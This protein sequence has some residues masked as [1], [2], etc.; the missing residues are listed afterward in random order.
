MKAILR[1]TNTPVGS[2]LLCLGWI[3]LG[4]LINP[5]QLNAQLPTIIEGQCSEG[6]GDNVFPQGNF[7]RVETGDIWVGRTNNFDG[8][9]RPTEFYITEAPGGVTTYN[10]GLSGYNQSYPDDGN[11]VLA[12]N[13]FGMTPG[14]YF[15]N[16]T[17]Q[18][19]DNWISIEDNSPDKN[20]H[21]M[22]VNA[23]YEPGIFYQGVVEDLCGGNVYEFT[24]DMINI[25]SPHSNNPGNMPNISFILAP[26]NTSLQDLQNMPEIYNTGDI[27][28]DATWH[29]YGFNFT[30]PAGETEYL[31]AIRN[32]APGGNGNDLAIDNISFRLCG[33][34]ARIGPIDNTPL[35]CGQTA[36]DLEVTSL[37]NM[38]SAFV[39]WQISQ[40]SGYTW[41]DLPQA[42]ELSYSVASANSVDQYRIKVAD[43]Q[44][45]LDKLACSLISNVL[46]FEVEDTEFL[47][48]TADT[49]ICP[50]ASI[51]LNAS[52]GAVQYSWSP[53]R[54]LSD[55]AT[56]NPVALP[57]T[58]TTYYVEAVNQNGC[59]DRDTVTITLESNLT[60][61]AGPDTSI[62]AGSSFTLEGTGGVNYS[63]SP[64]TGLDNPNQ[65]RPLA[66]PTSSIT[67]FLR[68]DDGLGC[69]GRDTVTIT[70]VDVPNLDAGPDTS[71][72]LGESIMLYANSEEVLSWDS[73]ASLSQLDIANPLANPTETTRYWVRS[74]IGECMAV[75]SILVEVLPLPNLMVSEDD[76]LCFGSEYQLSASGA[77]SFTWRSL[78]GQTSFS[79][80]DTLILIE[81]DQSWEVE[82]RSTVGCISLDTVNLITQPLPE[83]AIEPFFETCL[84]DELLIEPEGDYDYLWSNGEVGSMLEYIALDTML[85]DFWVLPVS[86]DACLGDTLSFSVQGVYNPIA[87]FDLDED[88]GFGPLTVQFTNL[89]RL[90]TDYIWDF[91]GELDSNAVDPVHVFMEPGEYDILLTAI[92]RLGCLDTAS[93]QSVEVLEPT[94]Y[95]PNSFSPNGDGKNDV[96]RIPQVGFSELQMRIFDRWGKLIVESYDLDF[97][98]DGKSGG[99]PVPEG[100]YVC[101]LM[102][103]T[104]TGAEVKRNI[105]ITLIR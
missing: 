3:S 14:T 75:D 18:Q 90:A 16:I 48:V 88:E 79:S 96:F 15:S 99:S 19:E 84:E 38:D 95:F 9:D 93:Y 70:V 27:P 40:D 42:D 2:I 55:S 37:G 17:N 32:N 97:G 24:V 104:G 58:S 72:C 60:V 44:A 29:T 11:Y 52:S 83:A 4:I 20:G 82:G 31:L 23:G 10:Y 21:M 28:N 12:N 77:Q 56:A 51:Q 46:S 1:P 64:A 76:S 98:W 34:S 43:I 67:Y 7:G 41:T 80:A 47:T 33:D 91:G 74:G 78:T 100:V 68:A 105:A 81:E 36:V 45:N 59:I 102:A 25:F 63:W 94:L 101:Q 30:L 26:V 62:C 92:N 57:D 69:E 73:A 87:A 39:Q 8:V 6:K 49:S 65:A 61:N 5:T 89:S 85:R 66:L 103:R 71:V 35:I 13:T 22:I 86:E 54:S 50:G 53:G